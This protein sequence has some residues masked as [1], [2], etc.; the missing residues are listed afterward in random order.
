MLILFLLLKI[1]KEENNKLKHDFNELKEKARDFIRAIA[2]A[3][4]RVT[5]FF[6]SLFKE[7]EQEKQHKKTLGAFL[8][9]IVL[10]KMLL[11]ARFIKIVPF[12]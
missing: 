3:P 11:K 7:E 10:I 12:P 1:L 6:K 2:Y 4:T 8:I 9:R 5:D